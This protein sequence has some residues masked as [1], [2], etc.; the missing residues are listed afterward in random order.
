MG[1]Q[2]DALTIKAGKRNSEF[3][4]VQVRV[5]R[6]HEPALFALLSRLRPGMAGNF[7]RSALDAAVRARSLSIDGFAEH[8]VTRESQEPAAV[9]GTAAPGGA[10]PSTTTS[11]PPVP[12]HTVRKVSKFVRA[13]TRSQEQL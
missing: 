9:A 2:A 12:Q 1:A 7:V 8:P 5:R 3:L 10:E 6:S 11:E 13:L 4:I